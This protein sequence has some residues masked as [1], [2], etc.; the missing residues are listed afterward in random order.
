[1]FQAGIYQIGISTWHIELAYHVIK[2]RLHSEI[3]R[4]HAKSCETV[5]LSGTPVKL[6]LPPRYTVK[7]AT[8]QLDIRLANP[9]Q[10]YLLFDNR[11]D[12]K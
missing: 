11:S 3:I 8:D 7:T 9:F 10:A 2:C 4:D 5:R 6:R 1:M 12:Q